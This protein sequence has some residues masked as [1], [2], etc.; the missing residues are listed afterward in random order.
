VEKEEG[1]QGFAGDVIAEIE[2]DKATMEWESPEGRN[3]HRDLRRRRRKVN[4]GDKIAFI[5]SE[6]EAAPKKKREGRN[7]RRRKKARRK[8]RAGGD[9]GTGAR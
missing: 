8:E 3:A 2:T 7:R 4:V 1:R 6:G 5:G 9:G